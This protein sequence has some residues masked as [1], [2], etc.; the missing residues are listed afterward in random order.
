MSVTVLAAPPTQR[1]T[2]IAAVT[3][4]LATAGTAL[5]NTLIDSASAAL[6]TYCH[7][8]WG[9]ETVLETLPGSGAVYL[10]LACTPVQSV[11]TVTED[12]AVI[13][14]WSLDTADAGRLYRQNGWGLWAAGGWDWVAYSSGYIRP[15]RARLRYTATYVAG[16]VLP[17]EGGTATVTLPLDVQRACIETVKAW[18][19]SSTRDP[20]LTRLTVDDVTRTYQS[21]PASS[22]AEALPPL[23]RSLLQQWAIPAFGPGH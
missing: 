12:D 10:G 16:Y 21:A 23:A 20:A 11:G 18:A 4:E 3:A 13:T 17:S 14:D 6:A 15:D 19:L 8:V 5:V 1:L 2:T 22:P 9:Q 7:R